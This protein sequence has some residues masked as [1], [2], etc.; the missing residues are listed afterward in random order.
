MALKFFNWTSGTGGDYLLTLS[1]LYKY[2][3]RIENDKDFRFTS[4]IQLQNQWQAPSQKIILD[5]SGDIVDSRFIHRYKHEWHMPWERV[6]E[7]T[8]LDETHIVIQ[9]HSLPL[10]ADS[11]CDDCD[12]DVIYDNAI[13]LHTTDKSVDFVREM[14]H[15]KACDEE[16]E[17][18][19]KWVDDD[20]VT[21]F[22]EN[23]KYYAYEDVFWSEDKESFNSLMSDLGVDVADSEF[24]EKVYES[25][26][27]YTSTNNILREIYVKLSKKDAVKDLIDL[28]EG[29]SPVYN[30]DQMLKTQT[31]LKAKLTRWNEML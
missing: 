19:D 18:T 11:T 31:E 10:L 29:K 20:N 23:C 9:T 7:D 4:N 6:L 15:A 3:N 17:D 24:M 16:R 2:R 28:A 21:N 25:L 27:L 14:I 30:F 8:E 26:E 5:Q 1:F 12:R 22:S 13:S